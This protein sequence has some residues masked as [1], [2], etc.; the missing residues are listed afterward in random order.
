MLGP[1]FFIE[2]LTMWIPDYYTFHSNSFRQYVSVAPLAFGYDGRYTQANIQHVEYPRRGSDVLVTPENS[3]VPSATG[4][5]SAQQEI[6]WCAEVA[7]KINIAGCYQ[8]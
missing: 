8:I 5:A 2:L 3:D 7:S 1:T 4:A 6:H